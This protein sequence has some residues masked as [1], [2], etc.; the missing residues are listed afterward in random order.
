MKITKEDLDALAK[1][2]GGISIQIGAATEEKINLAPDPIVNISACFRINKNDYPEME[3]TTI[4]ITEDDDKCTVGV[5][6]MGHSPDGRCSWFGDLCH[7][8]KNE[9][10]SKFFD[11]LRDCFENVSKLIEESTKDVEA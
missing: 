7:V 5:K 3:E 9:P 2:Y 8:S 6:A 1:K 11:G 4:V 10:I